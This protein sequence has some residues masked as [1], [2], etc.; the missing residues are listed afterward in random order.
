MSMHQLV[1]RHKIWDH[2]RRHNGTFG[3]QLYSWPFW[4]PSRGGFGYAP[5]APPADWMLEAREERW[6]QALG[7]EAS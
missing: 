2:A 1:K 3:P 6:A 4:R 5:A 7:T